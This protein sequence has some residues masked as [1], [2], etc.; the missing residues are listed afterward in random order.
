MSLLDVALKWKDFGISPIPIMLRS[1]RPLVKW[2]EYQDRVP[3]DNEINTWFSESNVN[4]GVVCGGLSNMVVL[5]FDNLRTYYKVVSS[6]A[7]SAKSVLDGTYRVMTNRGIHVYLTTDEQTKTGR[8]ASIAMDIKG[9]GGYVLTPPSIHPSGTQ[10]TPLGGNIKHICSLSDV[11]GNYLNAEVSGI[12][13][14]ARPPETFIEKIV[15]E[16]LHNSSSFFEKLYILKKHMNILDV[17]NMF[18]DME[19]VSPDGRWWYGRCPH[20]NHNDR[21]PS[22][23][24][25]AAYGVG[26]CLSHCSLNNPHGL[27]LL[28]L[29][30]AVT[31]KNSRIALD[32]LIAPFILGTAS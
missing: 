14:L 2:A 25:D 7:N 32:E 29:Y 11:I 5:D 17:A 26:R 27:D 9:K 19:C 18:T 24:V 13:R 15:K 22:F 1:K 3:T 23:R 8:C 4:L 12:A 31:G 6:L 21:H 30:C 16:E 20:P 10:Y 28:D